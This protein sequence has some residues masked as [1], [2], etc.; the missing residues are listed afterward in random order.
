MFEKLQNS[1]HYMAYYADQRLL[2]LHFD[3]FKL[4]NTLKWFEKSN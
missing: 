2:D 3:N 4:F 1:K